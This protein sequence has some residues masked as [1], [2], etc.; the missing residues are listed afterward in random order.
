VDWPREKLSIKRERVEDVEVD[1]LA[2]RRP[3]RL[4]RSL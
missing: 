3:V 2:Q 4:C 1:A